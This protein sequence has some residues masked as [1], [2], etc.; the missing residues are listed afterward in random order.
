V[1][2]SF[3]NSAL[4]GE[5]LIGSA[6]C[7]IPARIAERATDCC[8]LELNV[9]TGSRLLGMAP[10]PFGGF[11]RRMPH[12]TE[13]VRTTASTATQRSITFTVASSESQHLPESEKA[14]VTK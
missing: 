6:V 12:A 13:S 10:L 2:Q 5:A 8:G 9:I 14:N 11:L 4:L 7:D 3:D 1:P